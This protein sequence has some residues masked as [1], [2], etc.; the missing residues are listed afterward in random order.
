MTILMYVVTR[1]NIEWGCCSL[2]RHPSRPGGSGYQLH[3]N[4]ARWEDCIV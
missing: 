2:H 1:A 3:S 4:C